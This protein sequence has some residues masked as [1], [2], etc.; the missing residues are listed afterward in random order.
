MC[1]Y[2]CIGEGISSSSSGAT[3]VHQA[4]TTSI[5]SLLSFLG[6]KSNIE[7]PRHN[8]EGCLSIKLGLLLCM[9]IQS[10]AYISAAY[11]DIEHRLFLCFL[12]GFSF[13][14][15]FDKS[16]NWRVKWRDQWNITMSKIFPLIKKDVHWCGEGNAIKVWA[17]CCTTVV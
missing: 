8:Q 13:A 1:S 12:L 5:R 2:Y 10:E 11:T 4:K 9:Y 7:E 17:F 14:E 6:E 16:I 3:G 15:K